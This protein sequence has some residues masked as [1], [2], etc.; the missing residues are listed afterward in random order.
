MVIKLNHPEKFKIFSEFPAQQFS[1][2]VTLKHLNVY[3]VI[4]FKV[5]QRGESTHLHQVLG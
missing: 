4:Q 3:P 1:S 2:S 5:V